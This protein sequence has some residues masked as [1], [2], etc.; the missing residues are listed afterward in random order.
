MH[1]VTGPS[2]RC[3]L[4][5]CCVQPC[6]A[7]Y[8]AVPGPRM[9]SG[10]VVLRS[11][12]ASI[13]SRR[14]CSVTAGPCVR[15]C[16][17]THVSC[18]RPSTCICGRFISDR[19]VYLSS[20][21]AEGEH[22]TQHVCQGTALVQKHKLGETSYV[23]ACSTAGS[24]LHVDMPCGCQVLCAMSAPKLRLSDRASCQEAG[25]L[26]GTLHSVSSKYVRAYDPSTICVVLY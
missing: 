14:A 2:R 25:D 10:C 1:A 17:W 24:R 20:L 23:M 6:C 16:V 12:G 22:G 15:G 8:G 13:V 19:T 3:W 18:A 26:P 5:P 7:R 21:K 9:M 11:Y 4:L